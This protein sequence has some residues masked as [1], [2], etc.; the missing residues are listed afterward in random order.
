MYT[1][2]VFHFKYYYLKPT[3]FLSQLASYSLDLR[4][5]ARITRIGFS[6]P[7]HPPFMS[8]IWTIGI[9]KYFLPKHSFLVLLFHQAFPT[10]TYPVSPNDRPHEIPFSSAPYFSNAWSGRCPKRFTNFH[11]HCPL[12]NQRPVKRLSVIGAYPQLYKSKYPV[13]TSPR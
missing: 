12:G 4:L 10:S 11:N 1:Y 8:V 2:S 5:M 6:Y 3:D 7:G 13:C 9:R